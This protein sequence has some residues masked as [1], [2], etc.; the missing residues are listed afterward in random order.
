VYISMGDVPNYTTLACI[1]LFSTF[2]LLL[3]VVL[4]STVSFSGCSC[5]SSDF[6]PPP[7]MH[8]EKRKNHG[9]NV[10]RKNNKKI[11]NSVVGPRPHTSKN[12]NTQS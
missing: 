6:A 9:R 11:V 1:Q 5:F 3:F 8:K 4:Y 10:H 7:G 12:K 2:I